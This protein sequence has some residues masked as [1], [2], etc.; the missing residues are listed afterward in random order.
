[1]GEITVVT[2]SERHDLDDEA[3]AAFRGEWP[4]FIFH[5]PVSNAHIARVEQYFPRYDVMLLDDGEVVAGGWGVPLAWDGAVA[6]LPDGYDGAMV[7]AVTGHENGTAPD[8]L[9]VMAAAVK[10]GRQ[11][12]GL[13]GQ[14][15]T[16]LRERAV[17]DGLARV[18]APVRPT[19]KRR[20]PLTPMADFARW[21]RPDGLH[22][23]PWVRTHQRLGATVLAPALRS[24]II[25]G[26]VAEWE[27]WTKMAFPQTG[28]YVVPDA[29]DLVRINREADRGIYA[30]TNLWMQHV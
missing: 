27:D 2:S 25:T 26:S 11:G 5:D 22:L 3:R 12:Q 8:T 29:L 18:I 4:E 6:T 20:Y 14:V 19:L 10:A 1:M 28:E 24:M 17:E 7:D 21:S 15:L 9:S 30:E 16:A 23:D 13:A